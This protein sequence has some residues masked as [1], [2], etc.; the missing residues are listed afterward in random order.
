LSKATR[1]V[2]VVRVLRQAQHERG[3]ESIKSIFY[4]LASRQR[5]DLRHR[6]RLCLQKALVEPAAFLGDEI[7]LGF[8]LGPTV[9]TRDTLPA[10]AGLLAP[11]AMFRSK[12]RIALAPG[13]D[14]AS[15][16]NSLKARFPDAGFTWRTRDK[17]A[18]GAERFVERMGEFLVLVGLAALVIAGIGIGGGVASFLEA[19]RGNIATLKVLGATSADI[20]R[21]YLLQIGA[22]ALSGSLAGLAAG[23]A[24]TPLLGSA[25]GSLLPVSPGFVFD[26]GALARASAYGLLV[27]L[28]F[29]APPLLRARNFPA[30]ALMRARVSPLALRLREVLL[31][32][33]DYMLALYGL[34]GKPLA[35]W[36][37]PA[38]YLHRN[39]RGAWKVL[40]GKK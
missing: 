15:A 12:T 2:V 30:M 1:F 29:A 32:S 23:V 3:W 39:A 8:A 28:V 36:L 22:A 4:S 13:Q 11:G 20:A 18:P 17:A 24:V 37:L 26:A 38:L 33:P 6:H 19:R 31:P 5:P 16:V 40:S 7:A 21:I 10:R 35:A 9:I 25:L 14:P 34:R 27:A